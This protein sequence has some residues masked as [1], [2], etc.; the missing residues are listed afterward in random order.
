MH[1]VF[2]IVSLI[3][4]GKLGGVLGILLAIPFAAITLVTLKRFKTFQFNDHEPDV[5][6]PT[7]T[8]TY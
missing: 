2:I 3:I 5:L 4:C 8:S 6:T 1:P 7:K